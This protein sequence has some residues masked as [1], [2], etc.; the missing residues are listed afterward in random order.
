MGAGEPRPYGKRIDP[1]CAA[2]GI[3]PL[4]TAVAAKML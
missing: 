2:S 1:S 4:V 3:F